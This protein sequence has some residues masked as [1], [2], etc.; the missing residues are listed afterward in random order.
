MKISQDLPELLTKVCPTVYMWCIALFLL[1]LATYKQ[2]SRE[3]KIELYYL[4]C[5]RTYDVYA[6]GTGMYVIKYGCHIENVVKN[7]NIV[8]IST[9]TPCLK[10]AF[11]FLSALFNKFWYIDCV[12]KK[13][14]FRFFCII[15]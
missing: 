6:T 4:C 13:I 12:E 3:S 15:L 9:Y 5:Q 14:H 10:T 8:L 2:A 1:Y 11:L 7:A